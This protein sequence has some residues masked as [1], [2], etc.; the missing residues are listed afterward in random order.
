M[1]RYRIELVFEHKNPKNLGGIYKKNKNL[2]PISNKMIIVYDVVSSSLKSALERI[3]IRMKDTKDY[4]FIKWQGGN[5][6]K[7]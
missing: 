3:K 6:R 7:I 4:K 5:R 1:I 2:L